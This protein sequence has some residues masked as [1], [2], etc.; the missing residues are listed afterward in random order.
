MATAGDSYEVEL[1]EAHLNWGTYRHTNTRD[2]RPGEGYIPIPAHIAKQLNIYNIHNPGLGH[3]LF[4]VSSSDQFIQN[5]LLKAQG[6]TDRT[7]IYAKQFSIENNLSRIG[8]W[9]AYT[10]ANIGD[11]VRVEWLS[12]T[13]ILITLI[14]QQSV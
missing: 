4:N 12:E 6:G 14:S 7:S 2:L 1:K 5:E 13:N 10:N 8:E 3:N 9:Y 11:R